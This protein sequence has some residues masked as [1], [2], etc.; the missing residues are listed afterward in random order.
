MKRNSLIFSI[1]V[2]SLHSFSQEK[3]DNIVVDLLPNG[4]RKHHVQQGAG[5]YGIFSGSKFRQYI[6]PLI[7]EFIH[8]YDKR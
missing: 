8:K 6:R 4:M 2:I 3:D 1:L 5:H 7:S